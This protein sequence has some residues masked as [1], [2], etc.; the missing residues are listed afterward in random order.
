MKKRKYL[1]SKICDEISREVYQNKNDLVFKYNI[2]QLC[3]V[4]DISYTPLVK[5]LKKQYLFDY[6]TYRRWKIREYILKHH[7]GKPVREICD[8]L[9][10]CRTA[11]YQYL[12]ERYCSGGDRKSPTWRFKERIY[13]SKKTKD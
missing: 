5:R 12:P 9:Q 8:F 10:I 1:K 4:Y 13:F 7:G 3:S 2:Q 11:Y 6:T